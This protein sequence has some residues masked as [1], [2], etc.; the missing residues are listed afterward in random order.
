MKPWNRVTSA[1]T[2]GAAALVLTACPPPQPPRP[3][4]P[5]AGPEAGEDA[6]TTSPVADAGV[7]RDTA[8]PPT[9]LNPD[10]ERLGDQRFLPTNP[11]STVAS[12]GTPPTIVPTMVPGEDRAEPPDIG[13]PA[14][15]AL[16]ERFSCGT[17]GQLSWP[18]S[19]LS[20]VGV[21]LLCCDQ[22]DPGAPAPPDGFRRGCLLPFDCT[23]LV[24]EGTGPITR[25]ETVT[26]L[27]RRLAPL[28]D[29]RTALA[30]VDAVVR[31]VVPLFGDR[32][33][34]SA[35]VGRGPWR[36]VASTVTGTRVVE[37]PAGGYDVTTFVVP[38]CG[39]HHDLIEVSYVVDELAGV[40]E[41]S[42]AT[43]AEDL[44]GLCID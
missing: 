24:D 37:R 27:R 36:Y 26:E 7:A 6:E 16:S 13:R 31:D 11:A 28:R 8:P 33:E 14:L 12:E 41:Q 3:A 19:W 4:A 40:T 23:L 1:A 38:G 25:I 2:L 18:A 43:V 34:E 20:P 35:F 22:A 10:A 32:P 29:S 9:A 21:V 44:S 39:C 15:D 17:L 42:R 5:D 30:V